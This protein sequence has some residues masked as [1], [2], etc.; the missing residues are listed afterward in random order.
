[1]A[2]EMNIGGESGDRFYRYKMPTLVTKI[3]GRGNGIRTILVNAVDVAK[4]LNRPVTYLIKY[5]GGS[6][7]ALSN[8]DARNEKAIVNGAHDP[9]MV[10][11]LLDLFVKKF[12]M[13]AHCGNPETSVAVSK[14][15]DISLHCK[16]CGYVTVV[17]PREKLCTFI[18]THPPTEEDEKL[19]QSKKKAPGPSSAGKSSSDA[20][21]SGGRGGTEET[22]EEAFAAMNPDE[23]AAA[24]DAA[25]KKAAEESPVE[26]LRTFIK[27][28]SYTADGLLDELRDIQRIHSGTDEEILQ[29]LFISGVLTA[30]TFQRDIEKTA[31]AV[32]S[33][34]RGNE[35]LQKTLL[36]QFQTCMGSYKERDSQVPLV[37]KALYDAEALDEEVLLQWG[38]K[39]GKTKAGQAV[40]EAA[41]PLL[42]WL[43]EADE[44]E[45]EEED[46]GEEK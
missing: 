27:D 14:K 39:P 6:L 16:A 9:P 35:H 25:A 34:T 19:K 43:K 1:M 3:E 8:W 45:E 24:A 21:S 41:K 30:E 38:E 40:R 4:A 36:T 18:R 44:E 29:L 32:S 10:K 26:R 31:P 15:D 37:L 17:D 12:V 23:I 2:E 13:C 7:G 20:D 11:S 46:E 42:V 33:F 5:F 22:A 28:A